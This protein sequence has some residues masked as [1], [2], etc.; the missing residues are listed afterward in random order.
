MSFTQG[1]SLPLIQLIIEKI[2]ALG[3]KSTESFVQRSIEI[4][5]PVKK[6]LD[7]A[8]LIEHSLLRPEATRKDILRLCNEAKQFSFRGVCVNPVFVEEVYKQLVGTDCLAVTVVGFPLGA[9]LTT[10]KIVRRRGTLSNWGRMRW[11]WSFHW[12]H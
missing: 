12:V 9:N 5:K 7:L 8:P 6:P 10:T 1:N 3:I 2:D 4:P 11:I